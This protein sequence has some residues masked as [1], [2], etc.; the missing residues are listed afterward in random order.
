MQTVNEVSKQTGVSVR[1]LH[2]YDAIDLLKPA[3]ITKAGYRLYD[4]AALHRLQSILLFRELEFSI[5]EARYRSS[6]SDTCML[7]LSQSAKKELRLINTISKH[8]KKIL[9]SPD[10]DLKEALSQQI[11]LL[12]L[13]RSHLDDLISFAR[14]IQKK[15]EN[16]MDFQAFDKTEI[17]RYAKEVKERW[18]N[19]AA[20]KEYQLKATEMTDSETEETG[21]QLLDLFAGLGALKTGAPDEPQAQDLIRKIQEFITEHYYTCTDEILK[22]LGEMYVCDERMKRGIDKAGGEGTAEFARQ[23]IKR[24]TYS[25]KPQ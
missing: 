12:E 10:F 18:E 9:D 2:H 11:R 23:A 6:I 7:N 25:A 17:D 22:G 4:D 24:Y 3:K 16:D 15:G 1:T 5:T 20:Y 14:N 13:R 19:T 21:R 8:I